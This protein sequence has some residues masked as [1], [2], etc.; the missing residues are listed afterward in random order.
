MPLPDDVFIEHFLIGEAGYNEGAAHAL[1]R[2]YKDT[3]TFS[4]LN[5]PDAMPVFGGDQAAE[6]DRLGEDELPD[7]KEGDLIQWTSDG[8]D[9]FRPPATVLGFSDDGQWVFTDQGRSGIPLSE[10]SV[11]GSSPPEKPTPP[12]APPHVLAA[13]SQRLGEDD[14]LPEGTSILTKGKLKA[15]SFEVRVSGEIGAKEIGKIIKL[16]KA[17]QAILTDDED[18]EETD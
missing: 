16:L 1:I 14:P 15:G 6:D 5:K 12:P 18:E 7:V 17:Q 2:E 3:L 10:V 11:V 4:G 13:M 9:Q 8:V